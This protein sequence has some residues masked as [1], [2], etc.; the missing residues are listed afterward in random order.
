[1]R[2]KTDSILNLKQTKKV[3]LTFRLDTTYCILSNLQEKHGYNF[4]TNHPIFIYLDALYNFDVVTNLKHK[5]INNSKPKQKTKTKSKVIVDACNAAVKGDEVNNILEVLE[6]EFLIN[7]LNNSNG[8]KYYS[9]VFDKS[10]IYKNVIDNNP[11]GEHIVSDLFSRLLVERPVKIIHTLRDCIKGN[12]Q[13]LVECYD[14]IRNKNPYSNMVH[15]LTFTESELEDI[16]KPVFPEQLKR[17]ERKNIR[18]KIDTIVNA[19]STSGGQ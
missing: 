8:I 7:M 18:L 12:K 13:L 15:F 4:L 1:M 16:Y 10:G 3:R 11:I 9:I 19:M 14:I 6:G 17:G 5:I 2:Y